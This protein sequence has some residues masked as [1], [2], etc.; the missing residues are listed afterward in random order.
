MNFFLTFKFELKFCIMFASSIHIKDKSCPQHLISH[1]KCSRNMPPF[2]VSLKH[3]AQ[4]TKDRLHMHKNSSRGRIL[5][6]SI[7]EMHSGP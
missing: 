2:T 5:T 1:L 4:I 7:K 6:R 3:K